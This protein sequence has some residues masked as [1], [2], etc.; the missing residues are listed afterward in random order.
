MPH[1]PA[2]PRRATA[3]LLALLAAGCA[4]VSK[5]IAPAPTPITAAELKQRAM[6]PA[7]KV[8]LV[9]VWA[10]WCE[11]CRE[12]LPA[13]VR[14]RREMS[15][16][17]VEIILVSADFDKTTEDLV[18][19]LGKNGIDFPTFLKTERDAAFI[20]ALDPDWS[21][22]IPVSFL[23]VDGQAVDFWEGAATYEAFARKVKEA[24]QLASKAS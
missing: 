17:G 6:D 12:E 14:L 13:L 23:Y 20:E 22:A 15:G 9:N 19:F 11:P 18:A 10:T 5:P 21:G 24:L 3:L 4:R 16:Q 7:A 2:W 8:V 1:A